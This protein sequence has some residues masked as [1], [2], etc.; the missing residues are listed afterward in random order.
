MSERL[1]IRLQP[2]ASLTWLTQDAAGKTM[3]ASNTGAPP[4]ET[5]SRARQI[6]VVVP[7]ESVVLLETPVVSQ[8]RAHLARAIPFAL[9][10]QLAGP[11]ED[12]HF[13]F[14]YKI[15]GE[16]IAVAVVAKSDMRRWL[17]HVSEHGIRPD[18][19][20]PETLALPLRDNSTVMIEETRAA[21]RTGADQGSGCSIEALPDWLSINAVTSADV[22]DFRSAPALALPIPT[23]YHE[24]QRDPLT[25]FAAQLAQAPRLNLLQGEFA[26]SHRAVPVA[27]LWRIAAM[28]AVAAL[29]LGFVYGIGDLWRLNAAT[30]RLDIAERDVLH[31]A[32]PEFDRVAGDPRQLMDSALL[33]LRGG[34]DAGGMLDLLARIGS[35]VSTATRVAVKTIE[36]HNATLE[37]ALR[38]PDVATLDIVRERIANLGGLKAE[39]TSSTSGSDG[40]EGRLRITGAKP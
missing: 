12:L 26:P 23:R 10:D 24:R 17:E 13:A 14:P 7:A 37:I 5:I 16:R 27:R 9:E 25:L 39:I 11:V 1:L 4:S 21:L 36:Y 29:L 18:I 15:S 35:V 34:G 40:V 6:V 33:R 31:T 30:S 8:Q 32:F 19:V 22:F 38:A 3:S 20:I 28:L 2:D